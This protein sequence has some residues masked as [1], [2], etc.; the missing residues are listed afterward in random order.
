MTGTNTLTM[1]AL[2]S[3]TGG[4]SNEPVLLKILK[5]EFE[6]PTGKKGKKSNFTWLKPVKG[7]AL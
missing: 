1:E 4:K 3:V 7:K 6:L 5:G 2:E